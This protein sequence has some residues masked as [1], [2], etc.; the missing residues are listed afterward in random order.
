VDVAVAQGGTVVHR[1]GGE[2]VAERMMSTLFAAWSLRGAVSNKGLASRCQWGPATRYPMDI[3]SIRVPIWSKT[4]THG[5]VNGAKPSSIEY[6]G[7][8]TV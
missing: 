2:V 6:V 8:G 5:Y 1:L 3:Y 4:R 7:T